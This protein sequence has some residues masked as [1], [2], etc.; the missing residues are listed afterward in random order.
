MMKMIAMTEVVN[1]IAHQENRKESRKETKSY[2]SFLYRR[3]KE[4]T[5][6]LYQNGI[7]HRRL[8]LRLFFHSKSLTG[9]TLMISNLFPLNIDTTNVDDTYN[10]CV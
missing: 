9:C 4:S 8:F 5:V 1:R 10:C 3:G 7:K 6:I 2:D